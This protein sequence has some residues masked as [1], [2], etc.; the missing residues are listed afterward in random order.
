MTRYD[1]ATRPNRLGQHSEKWRKTENDP[2]L[3]QMWIADMDFLPLPEVKEALLDY[4]SQHIFGYPYASDSLY[5]AIL[6]WEEVEHGYKVKREDIVLIEGVV[7]AISI[8]IQAFT[9]EGEAVVINTP[10]YPPFARSVKLNN[11][12]LVTNSLV[13]K[14]GHFEI[15]F[16][17]LERDFVDNDVKLY[18]LCSPHN[19][20]GRVWSAEEL[21]RIGQLCQK[22]GV[23]LVSD[24]IHQDFALFGNKHH[25]FNTLHPDFKDFT[26]VLASATKTFNIAG[27]KNSFA[28]IENADLRKLFAQRQL[29]NNQHEVPTVGLITTE[30][31]LRH[32]K[33]W[34][35]ELKT[36]LE[37]NINYTVD[38]L[39]RETKIKVMKPEGTYLIWLDFSAYGLSNEDIQEKLLTEAKVVLNNGLAFGRE[40]KYCARFNAATP[41]ATVKEACQR[42]AG[43]FGK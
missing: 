5:Q 40:G 18:I 33:A 39:E 20:G 34:L 12:K 23:L 10:V 42:I 21:T 14:N 27:T 3:L 11:R 36:V 6:D 17:Q 7:P 38:F 13:E 22:Y 35:K 9:K 41:L 32:G 26:I 15:D 29:A 31:A 24:E 25:S 2:E 28:I 8:A 30:V 4:A 19:P 1:F 16:D 37:E 43:V